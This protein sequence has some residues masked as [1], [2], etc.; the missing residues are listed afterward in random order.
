MIP[1]KRQRDDEIHFSTK[2]QYHQSFIVCFLYKDCVLC[3]VKV[4]DLNERL[5]TLC[6]VRVRFK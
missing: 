1:P 2:M 4:K 6:L 3:F 5:E